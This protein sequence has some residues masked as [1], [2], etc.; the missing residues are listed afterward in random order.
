M[1]AS[2]QFGPTITGIYLKYTDSGDTVCDGRPLAVVGVN[3]DNNFSVNDFQIVQEQGRPKVYYPD[4]RQKILCRSCHKWSDALSRYCTHC[5]S[6][7]SQIEV[8]SISPGDPRF[9]ERIFHPTNAS[10]EQYL[11]DSLLTAFETARGRP[12]TESG[13]IDLPFEPAVPIEITGVD[14]ALKGVEQGN[15]ADCS[16]HFNRT[17]R[18]D[19]VKLIVFSN[20]DNVVIA[21][22]DR[23]I[24]HQCTNGRCGKMNP[25]RAKYC[26]QC[27]AALSEGAARKKGERLKYHRDIACPTCNPFREILV[28]AVLPAAHKALQGSL[29]PGHRILT[30]IERMMLPLPESNSVPLAEGD[31]RASAAPVTNPHGWSLVP[32]WGPGQKPPD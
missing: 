27:K 6:A 13:Y 29:H 23:Q 9:F 15:I 14:I 28:Q 32:T 25:L 11:V 31:T 22:P 21:M 1:L 19:G 18:V 2:M 24:L 7:L 30:M 5:R 26:G 3:F 8:G 12:A 10:Y 20:Q 4:R 17:I 16:V